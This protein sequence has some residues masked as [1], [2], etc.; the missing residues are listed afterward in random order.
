MIWAYIVPGCDGASEGIFVKAW[1][2][3]LSRQ[4]LA[5]RPRVGDPAALF[6][7]LEGCRR[8]WKTEIRDPDGLN[9]IQKPRV[10]QVGGAATFLGVEFTPSGPGA[11]T[12]RWTA[13]A[14]GDACLFQVRDNRL[15]LSFPAVAARDFGRAPALLRTLAQYPIPS[16]LCA[17]GTCDPR[18]TFL[19]TTDAIGQ[20]LLAALEDDG[21]VDWERYWTLDETAWEAELQDLRT[22]RKIVNDDCT[23]LT[24]RVRAPEI[25]TL[26]PGEQNQ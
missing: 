8:E 16:P 7:W 5:E 18:D 14:V 24:L 13:W 3:I 10:A 1:A 25:P 12:C 19:L 6:A 17:R 20:W 23:L 26:V 11:E 22:R 2:A 21:A 4:F 9:Y 15:V